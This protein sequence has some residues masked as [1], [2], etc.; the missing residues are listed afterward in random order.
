M[1]PTNVPIR[2]AACVFDFCPL[3]IQMHDSF[4]ADMYQTLF[5]QLFVTCTVCNPVVS[6]NNGNTPL[7]G[8][9]YFVHGSVTRGTHWGVR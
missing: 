2:F 6:A 4:L 3:N 5:G 9:C 8:A 7:F 1:D